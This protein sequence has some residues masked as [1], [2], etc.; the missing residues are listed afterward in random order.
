MDFESGTRLVSSNIEVKQRDD[1]WWCEI[2]IDGRR[3]SMHDV[4]PFP[5]QEEADRAA[6]D[7]RM[8]MR[9]QGALD[10]KGNA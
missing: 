2:M 3:M 6:E 9:S 1:G 10:V 8:M 4:G 5:S 7:F